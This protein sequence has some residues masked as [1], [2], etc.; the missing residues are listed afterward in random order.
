MV[1][2][3]AD[4]YDTY[5][6]LGIP[7][8]QAP[9]GELRWRAPQP[10][11]PWSKSMSALEYGQPCTQFWGIIAGVEGTNGQ[12]VGNEDCLSLNVWA[13]RSALN[14]DKKLPVMYWIHG[15]SNDSGTGRIYQGHHLAGEKEVIVVTINYRVGILGWFSHDIIRAS[16]QNRED[17]SGNFGTLDIIQGLSWVQENIEKFGGDPDNVTIFGESAGGRNV[18]S[19]LASPLASGLFHRAI[20]QSGTP[21]TTLLTLAEDFDDDKLLNPV[22]GLRNSSNGLISLVLSDESPNMSEAQIRT[23]IDISNPAVL[24]SEL[25]E[26]APEKLMQLASDNSGTVGYIQTA[27][28]LRDGYVLP[29]IST[30]ELFRNPQNYNN[31]PLMLGTNRDEQKLFM[32]RHPRYVDNVLGLLPR[33]KD[34]AYYNRV[35]EY[36]SDNW[37]AGAVDEPAKIISQT[38]APDVFAYRFDWDESPSNFLAD[39]PTL[40]GAAHGLEISFV[41]G[42]FVGGVPI[43]PL[44]DKANAPG[45][46]QLSLAM[47]DYW[48]E[49]AH[50][51]NPGKGFSGQQPLWSAWSQSG[52]NVMVL[53]TNADGG[54]RM[55][56]LRNNVADIKAMLPGDTI[57]SDPRERCEAYA[58]LFLHGYQSSDFWNPAEY[59]E[60]G[61]DEYPAGEFRNS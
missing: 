27:K 18:Y 25:R 53:D 51:G 59:S 47:M 8:A 1:V 22:S 48:A 3:F 39:L 6:W 42:D 31:V 2:G 58:A 15:G 50:N 36:V 5:A 7:Y 49:F 43:D 14:S 54:Q 52:A 37:K 9:V 57:I 32:S 16:A 23:K 26:V 33:P 21:D 4:A 46:K 24:L 34:V 13:P 40:L 30:L 17:A 29:K 60:L 41:F 61:C 55:Q 28:V 20:S 56:N 44:L 12:V 19:M 10:A 11:K 35:S 45:R 38:D